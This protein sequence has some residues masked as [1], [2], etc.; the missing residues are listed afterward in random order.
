MLTAT[1]FRPFTVQAVA[2]AAG[3]AI[4]ANDVLRLSVTEWDTIYDA[5]PIS[6]PLPADVPTDVPTLLL[7]TQD[8]SLQMQVARSK[9]TLVWQRKADDSPGQALKLAAEQFS[10]IAEKSSA[11]LIR[12]GL[13]RMV[14]ADRSDPG[15]ELAQQS[16][17][18]SGSL[19]HS[20]AP[21][22]SRSMRTKC[23]S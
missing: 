3:N 8:E 23:S 15:R 18:M 12:L 13:V 5:D 21:K 9:L 14:I 22:G 1:D 19:G 20:I 11:Q 10:R 4:R 7:T 16:V 6:L 2:F 17:A